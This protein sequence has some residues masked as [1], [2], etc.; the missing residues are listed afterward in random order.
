MSLTFKKFEKV[1]NICLI[2]IISLVI[3]WALADTY[4]TRKVDL[5][6]STKIEAHFKEFEKL[7]IEGKISY[8]YNF[9][10]EENDD[11]YKIA[12]DYT[13][14]FE[15]DDFF[16]NVKKGDLIIIYIDKNSGLKN[17]NLKSIVGI[18]VKGKNYVNDSC[19]NDKIEE[20]K[21]YMPLIFSILPII[22]IISF[23]Y[24]KVKKQRK[25][26]RTANSYNGFG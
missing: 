20:K 11:L 10:I 9:F 8:S 12:A 3:F 17:P 14:C 26:N 23:I 5:K 6:N 22:L 21:I 19:I 2:T 18:V 13:D 4:M 7:R 25:K 16:Q 24:K 1:F 15:V